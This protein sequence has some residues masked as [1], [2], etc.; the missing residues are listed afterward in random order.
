MPIHGAGMLKAPIDRNPA[1]PPGLEPQLF[2]AHGVAA[3]LEDIEILA[4]E[5]I[6][7][8]VQ[9]RAPQ[10]FGQRGKRAVVRRI[11]S[12]NRI[13]RK[14]G[15]YEIVVARIIKL[16]SIESSRRLMIDPRAFTQA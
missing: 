13:V 5:N 16:G 6:P 12:V 3:E 7:V 9:K 2:G 1:R 14:L 11:I 8:A 15:A 4:G 10:M